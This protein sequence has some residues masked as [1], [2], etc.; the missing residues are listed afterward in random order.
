MSFPLNPAQR[1]AVRYVDGPLLVLAGAGSGKTRVIAAKIGH[2]I[3][4]GHDPNRIVAITFTNKAAREMRERAAELLSKQRRSSLAADVTIRTFHS[5]GL[6]II[7]SGASALGLKPGFSIFDPDDVEPLIAELMGTADRARARA[8]QWRISAWKNALLSPSAAAKSAQ[9]DDEAAAAGAYR[10]Y[11]DTLRA[12]Q[13][14]DFDDLI[15]LPIRLLASDAA[16]ATTWRDRCGHLLVDEYQDTNPAQYRLF[17]LLVGD[18]QAFT[19]VG[20]DDQAIYGWRGA[21]LD[22]LAGLSKDYPALKVVK[23]EQNYRST[24]RIL[25]SANALIAN[26]PKLF[27]KRL[28]SEHGHGDAIR[29]TPAADDEAEAEGVV[30]RLLAHRFEHRGRYA[31]YAILYRGNHQAKPFEQQLRAQGVPYAISGGQ[32]Y[33]ERVEIKDIVA[34]LRLIANDDDDPAFV[35]AV[36]TPRRGVGATTLEKLGAIGAARRESLFAAVFAEDGGGIPKRQ[37][38]ILEAFGNLING[39]RFRAAREPA[40]R[41]LDE[42][43]AT[44]GYEAFLFDTCDRKQA[45]ARWKSVRDF[46]G[47][48]S[49]KGEADRKNLLE[50]TQMIALLTMLE[51]QDEREGDAVRLSTLHAAKGLEFP[52]AFLV[53]LEEGLLPHREAV[54]GGNVDEER[55]LFYVGITRAQRSLHLSFCRRRRRAGETVECQPS[56]FLAELAQE[57]LRW[58]GEPVP[59]DEAAKVKAAGSERLKQL[60]E[61]LA[62]RQ[63]GGRSGA[64]G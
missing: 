22:N 10:R 42:L 34:Y 44:I 62:A 63:P 21:S 12:Y 30:R 54:A 33:F 46:V 4:S 19:V 9:N 49:A 13:A 39:L 58:S 18:A 64:S 2:L 24:L 43:V 57:D 23:L 50:L 51:G 17:R 16:T 40:A 37:R 8:A 20:D 60:K 52:H 5:L 45:E 1:E 35:R 28:W 7:R 27:A 47:W 6:T 59:A 15:A 3:E 31:D 11:D 29:V 48:L 25:R 36:T 26:N 56:R 32:S 41:L 61:M 53:G 38:E 14:V 55:R